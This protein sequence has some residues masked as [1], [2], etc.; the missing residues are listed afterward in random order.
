MEGRSSVRP[1]DAAPPWGVCLVPEALSFAL[2]VF[3]DR[4]GSCPLWGGP[5]V[6]TALKNT[7]ILTCD[8]LAGFRWASDTSGRP[9]AYA[10]RAHRPGE[11]T[12]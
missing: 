9:V 8:V 3:N 6:Q 10:R 4:R 11:M 2:R 12:S 1:R 7:R 5:F